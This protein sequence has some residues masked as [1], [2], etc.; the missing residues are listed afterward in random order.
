[1]RKII[2]I[3]AGLLVL[4]L[5]NYSIYNREQLLTQGRVVLL[6]LAPVDPRSLMQG[7]YMALRFKVADDAFGR[8][9]SAQKPQD[10]GQIVLTLDNQGI[11][12][13]A[14]FDDSTP[15]ASNQ[16]RMRYRVRNHQTK[17]ASNAF[18]FQ[19][20]TA[21]QYSKAGYGEFRVAK[22]GDAILTR[23]RD[24]Q[25]VPLGVASRQ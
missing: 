6:Q 22:N 17:F 25:L 3:F 2:A 19:E 7:D 16:I 10:D 13:F 18:F 21:D 23:L 11:S 24:R 9:D 5:V 1:M 12:N 15:L 8:G 14:R 20:G 4:G